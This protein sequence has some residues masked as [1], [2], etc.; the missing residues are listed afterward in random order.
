MGNTDGV[1]RWIA[2]RGQ[3]IFSDDKPTSFFGVVRDVTDR[4]RNENQLERRVEAQ[5]RE[6]VEV[7]KSTNGKLPKRSPAAAT[8][9][10]HWSNH[11]RCG[12]RFQQPAQCRAHQCAF[13][14]TQGDAEDQ[15]GIELIRAAAE[16]GV[17]LTAQLLAVS[18]KQRLEPQTVDLN[19][20]IVGMANLVGTT[21]R[22]H[23]REGSFAAG[24]DRSRRAPRAAKCDTGT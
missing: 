18:R 17:E 7:N 22:V 24:R 10:C 14:V 16:R 15:E 19:S 6:F 8:A 23:F 13:A 11:V 4:K 12:A 9:R 2:T 20:K 1:E 21:R 3:T 5:T